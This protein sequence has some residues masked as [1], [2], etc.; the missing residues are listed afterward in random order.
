MLGR[1]DWTAIP[2]QEPLPLVAGGSVGVLVA[3]LTVWIKKRGYWGY[4]WREWIT[5]VDHKRIGVLY[6][7]LAVL[8]LMRGLVDAVMMRTHQAVAVGGLRAICRPIITT[9]S[10][11][12]TGRS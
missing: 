3:A 10:S 5:S 9:R 12:R 11:P 6:C 4:L 2:F 8:M 7:G 1:L